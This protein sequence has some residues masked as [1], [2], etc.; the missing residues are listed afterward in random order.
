MTRGIEHPDTYYF[1][2]VMTD[3]VRAIDAAAGL[4]AVDAE[5]IAVAGGSQ[6]GGLALAAAALHPGAKAALIDV[7]FLCHFPRALRIAQQGPYAELVGYLKVRRTAE[8]RALSTLAYFD[9]VH[10][11]PRAQSPALFSVALMDP[12]CPPST[13]FA[14]YHA[15]QGAKSIEVYPYNEHEG[16]GA[17][18]QVA[19]LRWLAGLWRDRSPDPR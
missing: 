4:A 19:Q 5:R 9:G 2:R 15:Y 17:Q 10:L 12:V 6:G 3:A 16:G 7:P 13:V 18:H 11:A 1:R 14:A 8:A